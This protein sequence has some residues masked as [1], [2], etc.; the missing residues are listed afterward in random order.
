MP[1][2]DRHQ[3]NA[4]SAAHCGRRTAE[5]FHNVHTAVDRDH[6]DPTPPNLSGTAHVPSDRLYS[7]R[8]SSPVFTASTATPML[9]DERTALDLIGEAMGNGADVAAVPVE[10]VSE[11]FFSLS[12][13]LAGEVVQKF[14]NYGIRLV[15]VGDI[16]HYLAESQALCDFVREANRGR[17]VWFVATSDELDERLR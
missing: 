2:H 3:P 4:R 5:R 14:A 12:S 7:Y 11:D 10:R 9:S 1:A 17:Q 15:L 13:G 16:S 8:M 6:P